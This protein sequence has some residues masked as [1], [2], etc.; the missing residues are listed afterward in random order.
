MR[1]CINCKPLN[2]V[3]VKN[4]FP[5]PRIDDLLDKLHGAKVL[6]SLDLRSA[7]HQI[8]IADE[9]FKWWPSARMRVIMNPFDM[10]NA[11]A[12]FQRE[13]NR[14]LGHLPSVVIYL[15]DILIFSKS[16]TEHTS[17]LR[18][19]LHLLKENSLN[20]KLQVLILPAADF[21]LRACNYRTRTSCRSWKGQ[22]WQVPKSRKQMMSFLG[23]SNCIKK[24]IPDYSTLTAPLV[25]LTKPLAHFHMSMSMECSESFAELKNPNL[26]QLLSWWCQMTHSLIIWSVMLQELVLVL[27]YFNL[28][29]WFLISAIRWLHLR[30]VTTQ[31]NRNF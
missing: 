30:L 25:A 20:C 11:P 31:E 18:Q 2:K 14:V 19:V 13:M 16:E 1:P 5:L 12:A 4:K 21:V 9:E 23:F 24:Y 15:D 17:H 8:R 6:P 10:T 27:H 26:L 28:M 22:D 29:A 7:Y 3:T